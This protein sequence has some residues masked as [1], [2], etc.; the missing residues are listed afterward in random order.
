MFDIIFQNDLN[1]KSWSNINSEHLILPTPAPIKLLKEYNELLGQSVV[2]NSQLKKYLT[3]PLL[4]R[5]EAQTGFFKIVCKYLL[6]CEELQKANFEGYNVRV[7]IKEPELW[8]GIIGVAAQKK[9][10]T[11][12][13]QNSKLFLK[14]LQWWV[15]SKLR[16]L[17]MIVFDFLNWFVAH[18]FQRRSLDSSECTVISFFDQRSFGPSNNYT[19]PYFDP[20]LHRIREKGYSYNVIVNIVHSGKWWQALIRQIQ[21][22]KIQKNESIVSLHRAIG[23]FGLLRA[24]IKSMRNDYLECHEMLLSGYDIWY[25]LHASMKQENA[26]NS[27]KYF[28][29]KYESVAKALS[30]NKKLKSVLYPFENHCWEKLMISKSRS[31]RIPLKFIG[32]QHTSF[33]LKLLNHFPS[34]A[35]KLLP[36]FPDIIFTVGQIPLRALDYYGNFLPATLKVSCALRHGYLF[37]LKDYHRKDYSYKKQRVAL[38]LS[39][40]HS[41]YSKLIESLKNA[42]SGLSVEILI[43]SHPLIGSDSPAFRNLPDFIKVCSTPWAEL[44]NEIDLL[45]YHDNSLGI[46]SMYYGVPSCYIAICDDS[47]DCQRLFFCDN[48]ENSVV[49][50]EQELQKKF[51]DF[52]LT[53]EN[54]DIGICLDND[55]LNEYFSPITTGSLDYMIQEIYEK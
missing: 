39:S 1:S 36:I 19:D 8:I 11:I 31:N 3:S 22:G 30:K 52:Y 32:Y 25:L 21:I 27:S 2:R 12:K 7:K 29:Y 44:F 15:T 24:L 54:K 14:Y 13:T 28:S 50:S 53:G 20:L 51:T 40:D 23:F 48:K 47:Y 42:C 5:M 35:E 46:E 41:T 37:S 38:A 33:S 4:G 55:Y 45:L 26:I 6:I 16:L 18:L 9:W 17:A 49:Y 43:K 10:P 34:F